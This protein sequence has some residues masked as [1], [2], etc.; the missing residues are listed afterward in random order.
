MLACASGKHIKSAVLTG[1]R[2]GKGQ[3]E[4]LT[5]R[6]ED[7]LVSSYQTAGGA[8]DESGPFDSLTL[9][10]SSIRAEYRETK[11]DGPPVKFGWDVMKNAPS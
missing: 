7:L 8:G 6:L 3:A 9:D 10:F 5:F 2:A 11:A 1:R 4:F